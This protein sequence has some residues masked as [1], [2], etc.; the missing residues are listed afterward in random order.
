MLKLDSI[1]EAITNL[2][3]DMEETARLYEDWIITGDEWYEPSWGIEKSFIN[4]LA[5]TEALG[6]NELY[7]VIFSE[8]LIYK[9]KENGFLENRSTP[10]NEAYSVCLTRVRLYLTAIQSFYTK[11]QSTKVSK[12]L[13]KIIR[14][15]HYVITDKTIYGSIPKSENDVHIRIEGILKC[16]FPDLKH[17]PSLTKA[18]KNFIPDTGINAI[19]TL[20]EYKF[21]ANEAEVARVADEILADTRGYV[22]ND[23]KNFIYVIY[24]TKRFKKEAEWNQL[25]SQSGLSENTTVVVLSG[26]PVR[27]KYKKRYHT[28]SKKAILK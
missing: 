27:K 8:Y 23:W 16:L 18:I 5:I 12:D 13:L 4:I 3:N 21:I 11:E 9:K 25:L 20:I 14:D 10:D 22:S 1:K 26:E 19:E 15:I 7:K 28:N 17:K 2:K 6:L 24:E